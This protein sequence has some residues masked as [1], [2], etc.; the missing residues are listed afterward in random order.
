MLPIFN[1]NIYSGFPIFRTKGK[2]YIILLKQ[3]SSTVNFI[4]QS[5]DFQGE[6]RIQGSV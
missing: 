4:L 6:S 3:I 5:V 2:N 1:A